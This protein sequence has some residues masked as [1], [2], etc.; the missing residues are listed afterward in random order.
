MEK[1]LASKTVDQEGLPLNL[2]MLV[3]VKQGTLVELD[4]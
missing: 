1:E 3:G 2:S 4:K